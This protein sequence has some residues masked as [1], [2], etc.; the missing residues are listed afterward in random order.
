MTRRAH[1]LRLLAFGPAILLAGCLPRGL[2]KGDTET[3]QALVEV[4]DA[5]TDLR[6]VDAAL[7]LQVDSLARVVIRQDSLLR[8]IANLAGVPVPSR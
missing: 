4:S 6:E 5:L 2:A 8:Q 1:P 7:Q 3:Q